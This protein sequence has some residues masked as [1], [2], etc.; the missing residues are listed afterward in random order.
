MAGPACSETILTI[1]PRPR[2]TPCRSTPTPCAPSIAPAAR[3]STRR[4]PIPAGSDPTGCRRSSPPRRTGTGRSTSPPHVIRVIEHL[5]LDALIPIGGD[6]TLSYGLRL[7]DEGVPVIAIPKTM[8]NDVHG[9]DYCIGF[10]TA[11]TRGVEFIHALRTSTGQP[12]AHRRDRA[13]R[14]VQ[15]RDLADHR[16]PRRGRPGG[17]LRGSL[18]RREARLVPRRGQ[19]PQ[20]VQL[21]DGHDLRGRHDLRRRDDAV[22]RGGCV[23]PPQARRDRIRHRRA[24]RPDH[25]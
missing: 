10:S 5:G 25:G 6:D 18:R 3:S 9:T 21:L 24:H 7:H 13:V 20:P 12:R 2:R 19:A 1:P 4:A 17:D 23:R 8:D 14:A 11:V 22:R 16:L 15:R